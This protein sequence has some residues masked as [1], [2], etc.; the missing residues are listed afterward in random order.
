MPSNIDML[1]I[2]RTTT[3]ILP[4]EIIGID[5]MAQSSRKLYFIYSKLND[6]LLI[7]K[8]LRIL[9]TNQNLY[10]PHMTHE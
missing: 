7:K 10:F 2:R 6:F 8:Y 3:A 4:D 5:I 1:A 9:C